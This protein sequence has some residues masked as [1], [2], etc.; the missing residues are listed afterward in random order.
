MW[1]AACQQDVPGVAVAANETTVCCAHCGRSLG[2]AAA[3]SPRRSTADV[4]FE[5]LPD[6]VELADWELA[7]TIEQAERLV[8]TIAAD[9]GESKDRTR[10]PRAR[11]DRADGVPR[12]N[13]PVTSAAVARSEQELKR[14]TGQSAPWL[15]LAMG[16]GVFVCGAALVAMS[17]VSNRPQLWQLGLPMVLG[18]QVAVLAAVVSQLDWVWNSNRATFVALH[19]M[20]EQLRKIRE[21]WAQIQQLQEEPAFYRHLAQG[22]SPEVLLSDLKD[23]IDVLSEHISQQKRAA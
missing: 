13:S 8:H 15:V 19:A 7:E 3:R 23:Q 12:P 14:S 17:L 22:A 4:P 10:Q 18:G 2:R 1:C 21:Q 9:L 16:L 6:F 5:D 20:D 11:R